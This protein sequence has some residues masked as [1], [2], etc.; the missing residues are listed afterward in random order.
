M[1]AWLPT[2]LRGAGLDQELQACLHHPGWL[3]GKL[4]HIGPAGLEADLAL[5]DDPLSR[6][7]STAVRQ[8]AHVLGPLQPSG[9]LA[10]TLATRLPGDGA[11]R[12]IAEELLAGLT[13]PHL[14]ALTALPDLPH[15][16]LSRVLTGHTRE[17]TALVAA[18]DGSW[19][20]SADYDG[21]IRIWDP[22]SDAPLT[23]L[24]VAG[25]LFHLLLASTTIAAAG[26][27]G[28]YFLTLCLGSNPDRRHDLRHGA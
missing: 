16:A 22:A 14:R 12:A 9:S 26:D 19:L 6:T 17:V 18:P 15:P 28:P 11:T 24:R 10:A 4:K 25:R 2:H 1:W 20:A 21:E 7:L 23:S 13:T 3:V 8:N 27:R 5:S